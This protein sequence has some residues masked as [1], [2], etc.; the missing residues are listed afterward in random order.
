MSKVRS[1]YD[2]LKVQRTAPV[3]V[4]KAAY[5]SLAQKY[6]PDRNKNDLEAVRIM[7]LINEAYDVLSD[8]VKR[9]QHDIWIEQEEKRLKNQEQQEESEQLKKEQL[10]RYWKLKQQQQQQQS[11]RLKDLS[12]TKRKVKYFLIIVLFSVVIIAVFLSLAM[13]PKE[14]D[15][16]SPILSSYDDGDLFEEKII[17]S[18]ELEPLPLPRTGYSTNEK[19]TGFAPLE[20]RTPF[21]SD[22]YFVKIEDFYSNEDVVSYFIRAGEILKVKL[23]TG[24]YN[25]KYA[26]GENWYGEDLLFG[27][28]TKYAKADDVFTFTYDGYKYNGYTIEL[29]QQVN[30]NLGTVALDKEK[31]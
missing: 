2:N 7:K 8:P 21:S 4:I 24:T 16:I 17:P 26:S 14:A 9:K 6:H 27:E 1:H 12:S 22:N 31:S 28:G 29:I 11:E 23:P 3:E 30:G 13:H 25:I 5:K 10:Q 19:Y 20:I 15:P 18:V